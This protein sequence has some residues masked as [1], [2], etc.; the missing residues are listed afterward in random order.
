MK[1]VFIS[2]AR[3]DEP[4]ARRLVEQLAD[5]DTSGWMDAAD[6]SAGTIVADHIRSAIKEADALVVLVS[7]RSRDSQWVN[8]EVGAGLALG[9]PVIPV[10]LE[11]EDLDKQLPEPL[12]DV[13]FVDARNRPIKEVA[14]EI[15][16]TLI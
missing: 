11:G 15:E 1:K 7:T 8:F 6:I 13:R 4:F 9:V 16:R 12:R 10:V 2:Y 14:S 5:F 3:S